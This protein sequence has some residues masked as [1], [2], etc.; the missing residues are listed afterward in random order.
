MLSTIL[1]LQTSQTHTF[2]AA[3]LISSAKNV[4][5][6]GDN[7][8]IC[9]P[10]HQPHGHT[11]QDT[12]SY[13]YAHQKRYSAI[14]CYLI[15]CRWH[16]WKINHTAW[17]KNSERETERKRGS[18]SEMDWAWVTSYYSA[19]LTTWQNAH[20]QSFYFLQFSF[21]RNIIHICSHKFMASVWHHGYDVL[22]EKLCRYEQDDMTRIFS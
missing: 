20:R 7:L 16:S 9:L 14:L 19:I 12:V 18:N 8:N 11:Q 22:L 5:F 4:S 6:A 17:K 10:R 13:L 1:L 15:D 21:N 2:C 3:A